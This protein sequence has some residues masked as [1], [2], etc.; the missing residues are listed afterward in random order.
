[1]RFWLETSRREYLGRE[2]GENI[3]TKGDLS[4]HQGSSEFRLSDSKSS[5]YG[6]FSHLLRGP[7]IFQG[8]R[9][10]LADH[11]PSSRAVVVEE[12]GHSRMKSE[13]NHFFG[14][15][16]SRRPLPPPY[17]IYCGACQ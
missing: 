11:H 6:L 1:M 7:F 8:Q 4:H 10:A 15:M 2:T 5:F 3:R 17:C 12:G 16:R 14:F 13:F 9:P